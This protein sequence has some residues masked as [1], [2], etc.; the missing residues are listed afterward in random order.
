ME[1]K[2]SMVSEGLCLQIPV[3]TSHVVFTE[4]TKFVAGGGVVSQCQKCQVLKLKSPSRLLLSNH[5]SL[6]NG[7]V[8]FKMRP[9]S[10]GIMGISLSS[11]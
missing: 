1:F 6:E 2:G 3:R 4:K 5:P 11:S 10:Y 9:R 7:E 8:K